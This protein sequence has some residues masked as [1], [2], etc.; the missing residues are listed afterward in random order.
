MYST[1]TTMKACMAERLIRTVKGKMFREFT[2]RGRSDW[3]TI[4]ANLM[5][6]YNNSLHRTIGMTPV[7]AD[8]N[9]EHVVLKQRAI[10]QPSKNRFSV[11]D[12]VRISVHKAVFT[13]SYLPS[14][15]TEIFT[16]IKVN[17]TT[18][19]TYILEDYLGERIAGGFYSEE[20]TKTLYPDDY[21]VEKIIR[22]KGARV[23][24]KWVG[25][26]SSHN[27]WIKKTE[28]KK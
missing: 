21:L 12:K 20:I 2:A 19:T 25:F 18:P 15:S 26:H 1:F 6:D 24:V 17:S 13:K 4:L 7:Q 3:Y 27:S 8:L 22:T 11:G 10:A 23:F 14:W 28:L 9:P 16:I 5:R